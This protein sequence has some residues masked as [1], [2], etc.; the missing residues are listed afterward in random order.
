ME[1][2]IAC[3]SGLDVHKDSVEACV[4]KLGSSGGIDQRTRHWGTTTA[5]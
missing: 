1:V 3:C 5:I 2:L 4:R